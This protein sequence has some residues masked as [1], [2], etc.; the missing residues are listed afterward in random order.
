MAIFDGIRLIDL[1]QSIAGALTSLLLA[2]QGA[3]VIKV[4][5]PGGDLTRQTEAGFF[6]W[7]RSKRSVTLDLRDTAQRAALDRMLETADVLLDT[8]SP[9]E[10]GALGLE[11]DSLRTRFPHLV[12]CRLTGYGSNH[13]WNERPAIDALVAARLGLHFQQPGIRRDGPTF[14]YARLFSEPRRRCLSAAPRSESGATL[15]RS[16]SIAGAASSSIPRCSTAPRSSPACCGN[17]RI[18]PHPSF[19]RR[20][21]VSSRFRSSCTNAATACGCIT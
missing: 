3:D 5:P 13:P 19:P 10:S 17:G 8:C 14:L 6:I 12:H 18:T 9:S 1:S 20:R 7:N 16:G 4:E 2:E 15:A 21:T 11:Q